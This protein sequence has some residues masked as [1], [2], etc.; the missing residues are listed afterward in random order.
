MLKIGKAGI[1]KMNPDQIQF[2]KYWR[3]RIFEETA[4][5]KETV[6]EEMEH[7]D[8]CENS[9]GWVGFPCEC[10]KRLNNELQS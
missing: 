8:E 6:K 9:R 10:E 1:F 3:K 2:E 7:D 4:I 5:D